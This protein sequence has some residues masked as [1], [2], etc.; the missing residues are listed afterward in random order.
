MNT[1]VEGNFFR[2]TGIGPSRRTSVTITLRAHTE[3]G[4][5]PTTRTLTDTGDSLTDTRP[6]GTYN[7]NTSC[8]NSWGQ[9]FRLSTIGPRRHA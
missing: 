6:H 9:S 2:H 1:H 8:K 5:L 4:A 7:L 3:W